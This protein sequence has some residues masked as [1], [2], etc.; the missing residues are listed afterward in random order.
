MKQ[1]DL[2]LIAAVVVFSVIVSLVVSKILIAP[3]KN[4]QQRV[5]V[6]QAIDDTFNTPD[7]RYFNSNALD[8]TLLIQ[9]GDSTNPTPFNGQ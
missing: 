8:P 1:K 3:P 2:A 9:I 6:V 5:E 4:R 7:S